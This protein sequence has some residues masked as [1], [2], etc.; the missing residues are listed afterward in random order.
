MI[1][2]TCWMQV[3]RTGLGT[4]GPPPREGEPTEEGP[5]DSLS[6]A[7]PIEPVARVSAL[8]LWSH[9]REK[10]RSFPKETGSM[11]STSVSGPNAVK[12]FR[13]WYDRAHPKSLWR[14]MIPG[15]Q[16][17]L[18]QGNVD[19]THPGRRNRN[20]C[21]CPGYRALGEG[22]GGGRP[23]PAEEFR[24]NLI[25]K[26]TLSDRVHPCPHCG[27]AMDRDQNTGDQ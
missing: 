12:L 5:D 27:L 13:T 3:S 11:P 10:K 2:R 22:P 19:S 26:K 9:R 15:G 18:T 8:A 21:L 7:S 6:V 25:V 16:S 20:G 1:S 24:D 4:R 14:S 23:L 17:T